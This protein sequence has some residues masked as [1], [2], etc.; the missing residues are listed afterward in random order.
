VIMRLS[1]QQLLRSHVTGVVGPV[2]LLQGLKILA[3]PNWESDDPDKVVLLV[4]VHSDT[5]RYEE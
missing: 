1:I 2:N 3:N 4:S 5:S